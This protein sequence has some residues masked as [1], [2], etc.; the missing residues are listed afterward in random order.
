MNNRIDQTIQE[1][2]N[3]KS[4]N[5]CLGVMWGSPQTP[6][7]KKHKIE[8]GKP[9]KKYEPLIPSWGGGDSTLSGGDTKK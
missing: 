6:K 3:V 9:E 2:S 1:Q 5:I 8:G 4:K 7:K